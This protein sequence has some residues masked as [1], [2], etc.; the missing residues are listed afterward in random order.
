MGPRLTPSAHPNAG[1][2][3]LDDSKIEKNADSSEIGRTHS[4]RRDSEAWT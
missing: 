2:H 4:I 1:D 3:G